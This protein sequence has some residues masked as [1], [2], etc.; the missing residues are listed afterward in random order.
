MVTIWNGM[1]F[2]LNSYASHITW[3]AEGKL[4]FYNAKGLAVIVFPSNLP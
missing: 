1:G 2:P 3:V 4:E